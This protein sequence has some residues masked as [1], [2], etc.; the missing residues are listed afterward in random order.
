MD[1]KYKSISENIFAI[2]EKKGI[3]Q[4]ELSDMTG[5]ATSTICDWRKKG[6]IPSSDKVQKICLALDISSEELLGIS[7]PNITKE[8]IIRENSELWE[9]IE[10]YDSMED[11]QK[12]RILHY[13]IAMMKV[14]KEQ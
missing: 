2:L 6:S 1:N 10:L 13:M 5:I 3:S 9:F 11:E 8:R 4:K 12:K 7:Q 14:E